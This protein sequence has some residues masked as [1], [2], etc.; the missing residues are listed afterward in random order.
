MVK[1]TSKTNTKINNKY[2]QN[3]SPKANDGIFIDNDP[4]DNYSTEGSV[5]YGEEA[6][7]C[8]L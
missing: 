7:N 6:D 4:K 8:D 3:N 1:K 2:Y 5:R